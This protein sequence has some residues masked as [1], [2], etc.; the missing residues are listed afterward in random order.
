MRR[1][2]AQVRWLGS[3]GKRVPRYPCVHARDLTSTS[4]F[5]TDSTPSA[6]LFMLTQTTCKDLI[7]PGSFIHTVE[8][9][10]PLYDVALMMV[11]HE[12]S[13]VF[14]EKNSKWIGVIRER[15]L[16]N[17]CVVRGMDPEM[18]TVEDAFISKDSATCVDVSTTL[19]EAL[20]ILSER[21]T[22][23]LVVVKDGE[24]AG[25]ISAIDIANAL[26]SS[27]NVE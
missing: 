1:V 5:S 6:G 17:A 8:L 10:D 13:S 24:P 25:S 14:V 21:G 16:T 12:I 26:A 11:N 4:Y 9:N 2:C 18:G 22:A 27:L 23:E 20:L 3:I 19:S 15:D 7:D